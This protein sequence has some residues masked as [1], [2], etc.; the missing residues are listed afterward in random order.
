[1]LKKKRKKVQHSLNQI[2][3]AKSYKNKNIET[4]N[5]T[6]LFVLWRFL[7]LSFSLNLITLISASTIVAK[8]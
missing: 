4:D 7:L 3:T 1:M 5:S 2:Y 8:I 6:I